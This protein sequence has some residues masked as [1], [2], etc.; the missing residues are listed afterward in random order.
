[1]D[2]IYDFDLTLLPLHLLNKKG[3]RGNHQRYIK[4]NKDCDYILTTQSTAL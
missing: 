4:I 1:M 2:S 3:G